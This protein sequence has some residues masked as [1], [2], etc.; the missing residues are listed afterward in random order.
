MNENFVEYV[1]C[2]LFLFRSY[3]ILYYNFLF[4]ICI[5]FFLLNINNKSL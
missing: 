4:K 5:V 2:K 3:E 1:Y